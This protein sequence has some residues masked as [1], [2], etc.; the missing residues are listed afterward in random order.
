[1]LSLSHS[2]FVSDASLVTGF[3]ILALLAVGTLLRLF[4]STHGLD[5]HE[6]SLVRPT[7][8]YVGHLWG[9][10]KYSHEYLANLS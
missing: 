5:P 9:L 6:P 1:M 8:P 10:M 4:F 3:S 2:G 7:V